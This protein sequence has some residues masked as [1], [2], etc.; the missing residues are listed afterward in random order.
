[1]ASLNKVTIIGHLGKDPESRFLPDGKAVANFTVA[2]SETWKDKESGEKKEKTEWHRITA[3]GKLAEICGEYLKKGALVYIEGKLG[4]R[5]WTDKEGVERYT[6]EITADT[7]KMLGG[8]S[9]EKPQR[10]KPAAKS[11]PQEPFDDDIPF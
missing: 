7:M 1:M 11:A 4:T 5:K 2:T 10:E 3:F 9:E 6:T 8:R